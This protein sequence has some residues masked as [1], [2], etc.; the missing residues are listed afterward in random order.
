MERNGSERRLRWLVWLV[1]A[2]A[3][4]CVYA[5][6]SGHGFVPYDDDEAI[7][8]N[9]GLGLG[10]SRAGI[11]WALRTTLVANWVPLTVLSL[12]ADFELHG[13]MARWVLLENVALH[14]LT[15]CLLFL[16]FHR[17]T[18]AFWKSAA[19][20]AV[21]ALHPVHVESVAWAAMR[22]DV[23]SGVFFALTLVAYAAAVQRPT[24]IRRAGVALALTAGLLS[25]PTLVTLPF[26]LLLL[27]DW[28]LARLSDAGGS[29]QPARLRRA[30]VEKL[31]LFAL[32]A[33][34]AG[35]AA[36]TQHAAGATVSA[37]AFP[38]SERVLNGLVSYVAYLR[39]AFW[40]TGLAVFYPAPV[41]GTSLAKAA[42]CAL[43]L[44]AVSAGALRA[45]RRQP[46]L[47]V[48]WL[49]FLGMLVPTLGLVQVGSQARAD[50]Y[51]YLPLIGLSILPIWGVGALVERWPR[52][53]RAVT[54]AA[55]MA[56]AL[57][58]LGAF[59]Q[60]GVWR[61]GVTLFEHA[62]AV[63]DDNALSRMHLADALA[64]QG[65][66]ADAADQLRVALR[67]APDS[68]VALNNLAFLLVTEPDVPASEPDE[69]LRLAVRAVQLTAAS[70]PHALYTLSLAQARAG[71]FAVA[72]QSA[73]RAA[74]L[75]RARGDARL[76]Q[77]IDARAA[78]FLSGHA[79]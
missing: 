37:E 28:P 1:L 41:G 5:Q 38:F 22:K 46:W 48:G 40:P 69:A 25:K 71:R 16:A 35:A 10:L 50:R 8:R 73:S 53:R 67:L 7:T 17:L 21:F 58:G 54:A 29:L 68:A 27:D 18:G 70:D 36:F 52:A 66:S 13:L 4:A 32:S 44:A 6:V 23:L 34:A 72:A 63:A 2:L 33:L 65:R 43:L 51:L 64:E 47:L 59:W 62:L 49:W 26:V 20:A 24:P 76:V 55:L 45:R 78:R 57:L 75:A 3:I 14:S 61:S 30:V 79:E 42:A 15:S 9:P 60:V 11:G 56:L 31:P 19:V 77:E 12:L 39:M 74:A